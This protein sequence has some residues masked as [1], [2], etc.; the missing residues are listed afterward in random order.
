[1]PL[2]LRL[3]RGLGAALH[4]LP[5]TL[6]L[7]ATAT[8]TSPP[9]DHHTRRRYALLWEPG[10]P[11]KVL[12]RLA[13]LLTVAYHTHNTLRHTPA[14]TFPHPIPPP[15]ISELFTQALHR[16]RLPHTSSAR[17]PGRHP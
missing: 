17:D 15:T 8:S 9:D 2:R 13:T 6:D 16:L 3:R 5:G 11:P 7:G 4:C 1:M 10:L 12:E 14:N